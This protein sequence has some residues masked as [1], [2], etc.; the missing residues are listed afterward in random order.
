MM[1]LAQSANGNPGGAKQKRG[2][3]YL[4]EEQKKAKRMSIAFTA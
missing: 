3:E 1:Y 2:I 4:L